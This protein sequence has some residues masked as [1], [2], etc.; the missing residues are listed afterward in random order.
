MTLENLSS[1]VRMWS[2]LPEAQFHTAF[3]PKHIGYKIKVESFANLFNYKIDE[4]ESSNLLQ[5]ITRNNAIPTRVS[6]IEE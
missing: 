2:H 1:W 3:V 4:T 6:L 5:A